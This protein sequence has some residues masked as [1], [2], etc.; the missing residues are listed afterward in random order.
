MS[1][2]STSGRKKTSDKKRLPIRGLP[3]IHGEHKWAVDETGSHLWIG[4]DTNKVAHFEIIQKNAGLYA[5]PHETVELQGVIQDL[6]PLPGDEVLALILHKKRELYLVGIRGNQQRKIAK[7]KEKPLDLTVSGQSFAYLKQTSEGAELVCVDARSGRQIKKVPV[8]S[9]LTRLRGGRNGD[10]L[11]AGRNNQVRRIN[12]ER[13]PKDSCDTPSCDHGGSR[14]PGRGRSPGSAAPPEKECCCGSAREPSGDPRPP[15]RIPPQTPPPRDPCK[16]RDPDDQ[17]IP[18]DDGV[19]ED[20]WVTTY[21]NGKLTR[22]NICDPVVPCVTKVPFPPRQIQKGRNRLFLTSGDG[23]RTVV[24]DARTLRSVENLRLPKGTQAKASAASDRTFFLTPDGNLTA[25]EFAPAVTTA[26]A[27]VQASAGVTHLGS[28][29]AAQYDPLLPQQGVRN[30]MIIPVLEPGQSYEGDTAATSNYHEMA[31]ITQRVEEYFKEVSYASPENTGLNVNFLWFGADTPTLYTGPP[32]VASS[33]LKEYW[34][35]AWNPGHISASVP[36]PTGLTVDFSGDE[37]LQIRCHPAPTETYD[38]EEFTI[39]FPAGSHRERLDNNLPSVTYSASLAPARRISLTGSD[40]QGNTFTFAVDTTALTGTHII[41]L[42]RTAL[43][44]NSDPLDTIADTLEELLEAGAPGLFE[45]PSVIWH[46]DE[47]E[48]GMLHVSVAFADGLGGQQ[49]VLTDFDISDLFNHVS[50]SSGVSKSLAANFDVNNDVSRLQTYLRRI[51]TDA[52]VRHPAFGARLANSYFEMVKSDWRPWVRLDAGQLETRINLSTSHGRYPSRITLVSQSGLEKLGFDAPTEGTGNDTDY[53]GG[54]GPT[55]EK[56]ALFNE[57]Y[58]AMIEAAIDEQGE[59]EAATNFNR[60]FNCIGLED[61]PLQCALDTIHSFVITPVYP[62]PIFSGTNREPDLSNG[63]RGAARKEKMEDLNAATRSHA[64]YPIS[65]SRTKIVMKLATDSATEYRALGSSATLAHEL[66]HTLLGYS[67]LY[68]GGSYRNQVQYVDNLCLMGDTSSFSHF[69]AYHKRIKGWLSDDATVVFDRPSDGNPLDTEIILAQ[70]EYYD[71]VISQDEWSDIAQ[72]ALPN[73]PTGLPVVAA[74]FLRLGGDGRQF[75]VLELRGQG[76]RFSRELNPPRVAITNA[77]DPND[78]TRYGEPE[79]EG[80]GTTR[81][82]LERY[83]RKVHLLSTGL[84]E[85]T[86]GSP[87]ATFNFATDPT[88]PELGLEAELLEWGTATNAQGTFNLARVRLRWDRGPAIN[89]GFLEAL[90]DWQSPD[91]AVIRPEDIAVDGSF[92]FPETQ[93]DIERFRI[94]PGDEEVMHKVAVR[95]W[96]FGDETAENV[97]IGLLRRVPSGG[98]AGDW[99]TEAEFVEELAAPLPPYSEADPQIVSFDW[100]VTSSSHPHLCF[101]A[102]IGD[103]DVPRDDNGVALA[104][105]DTDASNDW[106]QQNVFEFEA[107]ADSPPDPV[108]FTFEVNNKGSYVEK[109]TLVPVGLDSGATV[110]IYPSHMQIAPF[111]R[112]S[113]RVQVQLEERLLDALCNKDIDFRLEVW[114][115]DDHTQER[116]GSS[117]YVIKPRRRTKIELDGTIS[118]ERVRLFGA[119][120]PDIGA[121]EI[122]LNIKRANEPALWE[123]ITLGPASTFDFEL[124]GLFSAGD[125]VRAVAYFDG[126]FEHAKSVSEEITLSWIHEG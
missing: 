126:S 51:L 88:F 117:R 38:E 112:G 46:D 70:L 78:D 89:L 56:S 85:A 67:D 15:S 113:F 81:S 61:N 123:R 73:A 121:Q 32:I 76:P 5:E 12:V 13:R 54:G 90:P 40:R 17:C 20:C 53:S 25:Q 3:K 52:H 27:A 4:K 77:I 47:S 101:R 37:Q 110:M 6:Y 72:A 98:G 87:E 10:V 99:E 11:L 23:R 18:G 80:A 83:R 58:T 122:L 31:E 118:P 106:A 16:P 95:V 100:N 8:A 114:R 97:E 108:H 71:P 22:V 55:L 116:W 102:M 96:N 111:S 48:T 105:D 63:E 125:E 1:D 44:A 124:T 92:E 104:S 64:F 50:S 74:A 30:V 66:G 41:E 26:A 120:T 43:E 34:G 33:P 39:R 19:T 93:E 84:R 68:S 107:P 86:I 35:D 109:V 79:V 36:A 82:V 59:A 94:P 21:L 65:A 45:R 60:V 75:N 29:P 115:D 14:P 91:I 103:R 119:V 2:I 62:G 57:V 69:C 7:L 9:R 49:P 24:L 28:S 42:T